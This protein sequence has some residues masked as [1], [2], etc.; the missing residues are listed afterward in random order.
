MALMRGTL[1]RIVPTG[2]SSILAR[3]AYNVQGSTRAGLFG[4]SGQKYA[5]K[6]PEQILS[7]WKRGMYIGEGG[8]IV[9]T[10]YEKERTMAEEP[11]REKVRYGQDFKSSGHSQNKTIGTIKTSQG[12]QALQT[13]S[14]SIFATK[15]GKARAKAQKGDIEDPTK[16]KPRQGIPQ[17]KVDPILGRAKQFK[18]KKLSWSDIQGIKGLMTKTASFTAGGQSGAMG[19]ALGLSQKKK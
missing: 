2:R 12:L 8:R 11:I 15:L 4:R 13:E 9:G 17:Q 6:S 10:K 19:T 18:P 5:K 7:L 3:Q 1:T 16:S 14:K